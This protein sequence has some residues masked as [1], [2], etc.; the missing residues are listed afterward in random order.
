MGIVLASANSMRR[1]VS[2]PDEYDDDIGFLLEDEQEGEAQQR[3]ENALSRSHDSGI[4]IRKS[5]VGSTSF[6][7]P[8]AAVQQNHP[9]AARRRSRGP[10][11]G[12]KQL[13]EGGRSEIVRISTE[14]FLKDT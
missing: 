12:S 9:I 7:L 11:M 2:T 5:T 1:R 6:T 3:S 4:S 13:I 8:P 10:T 14:I